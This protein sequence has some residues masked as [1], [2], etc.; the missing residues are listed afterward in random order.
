MSEQVTILY[1]ECL[2]TLIQRESEAKF[3]KEIENEPERNPNQTLV[4]KK[5]KHKY[6]D[7][8]KI[9]GETKQKTMQ[10]HTKSQSINANGKG[11]PE[12][13]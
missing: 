6:R 7:E 13:P 11:K 2:E 4:G 5:K 8:T 10:R 9:L 12:K 3:A 1:K